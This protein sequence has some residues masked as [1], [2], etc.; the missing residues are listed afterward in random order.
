PTRR[1]S[2]L[3]ISAYASDS[4]RV[5]F[6]YHDGD[7]WSW[8]AGLDNVE[9]YSIFPVDLKVSSLVRPADGCSFGGTDSVEVA[10]ANLG[11]DTVT[12][13]SVSYSVDGGTVITENVNKV[14]PAFDTITHLF[15][16]TTNMASVAT[17]QVKAY[18]TNSLDGDHENDTLNT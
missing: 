7:A 10:I 12:S 3:N 5:R 9:I 17:Y 13:F 16:T 11:Q 2:D 6:V 15:N 4:A 18:V 1:S 8:Y 14:I